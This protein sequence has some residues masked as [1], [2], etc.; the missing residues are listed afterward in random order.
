MSGSGTFQFQK[1][2]V[3]YYVIN[4]HCGHQY[5]WTPDIPKASLVGLISIQKEVKEEKIDHK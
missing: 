4:K 2:F 1:I 3:T 5:L